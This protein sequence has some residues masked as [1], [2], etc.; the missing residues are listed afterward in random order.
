MKQI[1][2]PEYTKWA[3]KLSKWAMNNDFYWEERIDDRCSKFHP[4]SVSQM[5]RLQDNEKVRDWF[6]LNP[7]P[8]K[9][10][11]DPEYATMQQRI[12]ELE[13]RCNN[14]EHGKDID[15]SK[16]LREWHEH[17]DALSIEDVQ[18]V[19]DRLLLHMR[20]NDTLNTVWS[21]SEEDAHFY[22]DKGLEV[23]FSFLGS[24]DEY[25]MSM[26]SVYIDRFLASRN[27]TREQRYYEC[28]QADIDKK[29]KEKEGKNA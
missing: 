21:V 26:L 23:P 22:T 9:T 11:D 10:I 29:L 12:V 18:F 8:A 15:I 27:K 16:L 28:L 13:E 24:D 2:N 1:K 7:M 6:V 17:R 5:L 19:V 4:F 14:L 3:R 25:H 20:Y